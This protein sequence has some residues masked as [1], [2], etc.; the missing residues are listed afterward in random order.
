MGAQARVAAVAKNWASKLG[1]GVG[2]DGPLAP[3]QIR[4]WRGGGVFLQKSILM[5]FEDISNG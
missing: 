1:V 5:W 4:T 3:L 2:E